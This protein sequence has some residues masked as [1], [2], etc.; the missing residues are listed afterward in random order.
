MLARSVALGLTVALI[1]LAQRPAGWT[2][3]SVDPQRTGWAKSETELTKDN[4]KNL[5]L[6]WSLKLDNAAKERF[7]SG[8]AVVRVTL[9]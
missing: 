7:S 1:A 3:F 8:V 9:S 5:K 6:Q 2:T 4:I